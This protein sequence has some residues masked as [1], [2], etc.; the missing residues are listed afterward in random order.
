MLKKNWE[1]DYAYKFVERKV[2]SLELLRGNITPLF[3]FIK[4]LAWKV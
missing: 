2:G 4:I 3:I 1:Y